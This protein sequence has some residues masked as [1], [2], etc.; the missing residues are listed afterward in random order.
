L[1]EGAGA[2]RAETLSNPAGLDDVTKTAV[3]TLRNNVD[4]SPVHFER[5]DGIFA[6]AFQVGAGY[7]NRPIVGAALSH[8]LLPGRY[9]R[10]S[11]IPAASSVHTITTMKPI[12]MMFGA[13]TLR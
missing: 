4:P 10:E 8:W 5:D 1:P 2:S 11:E 6:D 12:V 9:W 3:E 7:Q 13:F